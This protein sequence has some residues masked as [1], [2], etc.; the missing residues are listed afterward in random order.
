MIMGSKVVALNILRS[1]DVLGVNTRQHL[2]LASATMQTR[3][4]DHW[5]TEGVTIVD[6]CNTYIDSRA[7]IG[8]DTI[9]YPFTVI[10]GIVKIGSA[11]H[12]G[13]Y[14]HLRDGT[15]LDDGV[16]IGAFVEIKESHLGAGT[17]VRHLAYIGDAKVGEK[18]NI[19][20]TAITANFDGVKKY[21]T[22][23]GTRTRLGAGAILIAPVTIGDD[24]VVGAGAVVT[25]NQ[26]IPDGQTIIGV[27]AR[28]IEPKSH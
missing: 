8:T 4:Q 21:K 17:V 18:A 14:A 11:C 5:M 9:I 28:P 20:A 13:P 26:S 3:I 2:A 22:Q 12:V 25:R 27:P 6:P 23:I 7:T 24:V 10:T 15:V 19:G 16:E 1:D